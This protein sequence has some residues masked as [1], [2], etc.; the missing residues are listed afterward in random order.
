[1]PLDEAC[2]L[3]QT[4]FQLPAKF[5]FEIRIL[6]VR[7]VWSFCDSELGKVLGFGFVWVWM[8]FGWG[9]PFQFTSKTS[10]CHSLAPKS[11]ELY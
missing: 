7:I 10:P 4:G 5:L 3:K 11:W 1:M 6:L 9:L 2:V 8:G